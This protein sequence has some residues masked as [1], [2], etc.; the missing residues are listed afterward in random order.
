MNLHNE[1]GVKPESYQYKGQIIV[2]LD[3]VTHGEHE[4]L[5]EPLVV[6]RDLI[7]PIEH[8]DGRPTAVHRR[9]TVGLSE[10][11]NRVL[12]GVIKEV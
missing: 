7:A 3:V 1:F 8:R 2:V 9:Y 10:W 5:P 6:Y 4:A 12:N 11:K